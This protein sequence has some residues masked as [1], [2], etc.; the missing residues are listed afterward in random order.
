VTVNTTAQPKAVS[1]DKWL[2]ARV[3]LLK[4]EKELTHA[5][6]AVSAQ[7]RALPWVK[8]EK[9]YVFDTLEGKKTLTDLFDGRS[10]LIIYH[11]MWRRELGEGCV[12]CSFLADHI[13]GPNRHLAQHDVSFV[14]VSHAPLPVLQA[15]KRRMGWRFPWVSSLGSDFNFD[16]H[17]S[18]TPEDLA[19]GKVFYNYR[20]TDASI[21]ELSGISVFYK[22]E[23]GE[24][25]HTYSSYARGNEEV[26][27]AYMYLDLTPKGRNETG[28]HY[29]LADWVRHHDR[30][31]AGGF[32]DAT[33]G[34]IAP[35][36]ATSCC[37]SAET[38]CEMSS[39]SNCSH[40]MATVV[41]EEGGLYANTR[42]LSLV[43]WKGGGSDE[44]L[45]LHF[46]GFE[47]RQNQP[48]R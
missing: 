5:R 41:R 16:Y 27:G 3:E 24:I 33:G 40:P 32:V 37:H 43:R 20:M 35:K 48:P 21:E 12:G 11:F 47:K 25:F 1:R 10:Q 8:V 4:K 44:L 23:T 30:Y 15:F 26:L 7:R 46:P 36:P 2:A 29:T 13:D 39:R 17:V 38:A 45:H 42:H 31:G 18:F 6:D 34:Y 19:K 9:E 22:D 14:V 28:P